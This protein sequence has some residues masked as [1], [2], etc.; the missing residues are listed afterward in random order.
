MSSNRTYELRARTR[1]GVAAQSGRV[2]NKSP[3]LVDLDNYSNEVEPL[4][5]DLDPSAE[6]AG[7]VRSYRD[8]VLSR[9]PF[10]K[11]GEACTA[12]HQPTR[13]A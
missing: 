12:F 13:R 1:A 3:S 5:G 4:R 2:L 7:T 6:A 11:K 10:A 8:V 9:P